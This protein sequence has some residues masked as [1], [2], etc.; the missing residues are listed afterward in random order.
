VQQ[1]WSA[2]N[3]EV[4][5]TIVTYRFLAPAVFA[6]RERLAESLADQAMAGDG[7]PRGAPWPMRRWLGERL[8]QLGTRLGGAGVPRSTTLAPGKVAA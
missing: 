6:A 4:L 7:A 5:N 2:R 3:S 8:V 1:S